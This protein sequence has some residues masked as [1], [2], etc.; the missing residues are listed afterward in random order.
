MRSFFCNTR[1]VQVDA[2]ETASLEV[3]FLPL[4]V[5]RR[6]CTVILTDDTLGEFLYL[7]AGNATAPLP[8]EVPP[9]QCSGAA[10]VTRA[11]AAGEDISSQFCFDK[12]LVNI[13]WEDHMFYRGI[14]HGN[15]HVGKCL[16]I[17]SQWTSGN[18]KICR[19]ANRIQFSRLAT[20]CLLSS[21]KKIS[22]TCC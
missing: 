9:L 10:R 20:L 5:G 14:C 15:Q 1:T 2:C 21:E 16:P 12:F 3:L 4:V 11:S 8:E 7:I 13:C 19:F 6:Q 22:L 17:Q 18:P